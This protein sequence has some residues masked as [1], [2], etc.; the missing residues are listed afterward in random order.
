MAWKDNSCSKG[1]TGSKPLSS[2]ISCVLSLCAPIDPMLGSSALQASSFCCTICANSA[3]RSAKPLGPPP[4]PPIHE[5][6]RIGG[7]SL[8]AEHR[9]AS[10]PASRSRCIPRAGNVRG[11][12]WKNRAAASGESSEKTQ[13]SKGTKAM[14]TSFRVFKCL[15]AGDLHSSLK[16]SSGQAVAR[17][18]DFFAV[19]F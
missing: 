13:D 11:L 5:W 19:D 14:L 15:A 1:L 7:Y 3:H 2:K 4:P 12:G 17:Q 8:S 18:Y 10:C 16:S 6:Y 9:V